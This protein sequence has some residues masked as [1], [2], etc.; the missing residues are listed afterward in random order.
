MSQG[1][2]LVERKSRDRECG[3]AGIPPGSACAALVYSPPETTLLCVSTQPFGAPVVPGVYVNIAASSSVT[4]NAALAGRG[5][6]SNI[7]EYER[8]TRMIENMLFLARSDNAQV[9]LH[10]DT[11]SVGLELKRIADYFEG[12]AD[13][14]DVMLDVDASGTLLADADL[15]RRAVSNLVANAMRHTPSGERVT[16]RGHE[17]APDTFVVTVLNPGATLHGGKGPGLKRT[18]RLDDV[19]PGLPKELKTRGIM[20]SRADMA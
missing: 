3:H 19:Q 11:I 4:G 18:R 13:E 17:Q 10:K 15:F 12:M 5:V 9:A 7:E 6:P 20:N 2:V 16:I 1:E 14:K 8:L